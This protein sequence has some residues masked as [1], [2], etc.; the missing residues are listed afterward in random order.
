MSDQDTLVRRVVA[1]HLEA[2]A[3]KRNPDLIPAWSDDADRIVYVKPESIG[4]DYEKVPSSKLDSEGHMG[5]P[6]HPGGRRMRK[7]P[8]RPRRPEIPRRPPPTP[9][10][11]PRPKHPP[12]P[13]KRPKKI[14]LVPMP[15]VPKPS[16]KRD[17]RR[18][19][20]FDTRWS[21]LLAWAEIHGP[22]TDPL[23]LRIV[24]RYIRENVARETR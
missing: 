20:K 2:R 10:S 14:P 3:Y 1:R 16:P 11:P 7:L 8:K 17:V 22:N 18:V 12:M 9:P 13:A 15:R 23:L 5:D 4:E 6:K 19:K 21:S 24:S